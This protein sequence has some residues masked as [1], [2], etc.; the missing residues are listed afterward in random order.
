MAITRQNKIIK[1]RIDITVDAANGTFKNGIDLDK[2]ADKIIGI[3]L[4]SNKDDLLYYRG[5]QKIIINEE[6]F[7][8]EGFESKLLMSGLNVPPNERMYKLGSIDPGNRKVEIIFTDVENAYAAFDTY[9]VTLHVY[10]TMK[11]D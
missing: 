8:P 1:E 2:N 5:T 6:E 11:E 7:F 4:I 3:S 10:S 9:R